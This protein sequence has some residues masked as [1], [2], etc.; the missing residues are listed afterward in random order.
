MDL[1]PQDMAIRFYA[2][3]LIITEAITQNGKKYQ[4]FNLPYYLASQIQKYIP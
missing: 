4:L 2:E 1:A 3:E